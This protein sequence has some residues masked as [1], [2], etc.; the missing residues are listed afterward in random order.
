[1]CVG[2]LP[3]PHAPSKAS[4][5]RHTTQEADFHYRGAAPMNSS[6]SHSAS[7]ALQ[8][9]DKSNEGVSIQA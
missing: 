1:M 3:S 8:A 6:P 2:L 4:K 9:A 5:G 7:L